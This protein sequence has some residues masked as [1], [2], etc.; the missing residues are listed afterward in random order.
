MSCAIAM[1]VPKARA[2]KSTGF[3]DDRRVGNRLTG[4]GGVSLRPDLSRHQQDRLRWRDPPL[5]HVDEVASDD[6]EPDDGS[7]R[8]LIVVLALPRTQGGSKPCQTRS[9]RRICRR[10]VLMFNAVYTAYQDKLLV[11]RIDRLHTRRL[12]FRL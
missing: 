12:Q 2:P 3:V 11:D 1:R 7:F 5:H 4:G 9:P 6:W 8:A 10:S